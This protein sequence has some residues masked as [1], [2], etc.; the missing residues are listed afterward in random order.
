MQKIALITAASKGMGAACAR[1]FH[2][3]GYKLALMARGI[4]ELES[5]A[6]ELSAIGVQGT[7]TS[8]GDLKRLVDSAMGAY[9]RIDVVVNNTGHPA[10]E[11]LLDLSEEAWHEGLDLVLMNVIKMC[12]LV[13]PI[14]LK[15][16]GGAFINISTFAAFEPSLDFPISSSLRAS[17]G[18]FSKLFSDKYASD[19]IRMNNV[20]PGFI[21]SYE[22]SDATLKK[23]PMSRPGTVAEIA[24]TVAYLASEDSAYITGQNIRVDGGLTRSV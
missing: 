6:E 19:N 1:E 10:K 24:K 15:Q 12:K 13:T 2:A 4:D 18:S 7:V 8:K 9:G 16:G 3:N 11:E 5:V 23:I 17:L 22:V 21:D 20:L 14:M